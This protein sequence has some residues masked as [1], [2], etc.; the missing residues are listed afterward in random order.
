E[1]LQ[2]IGRESHAGENERRQQRPTLGGKFLDTHGA[3][4]RDDLRTGR[5]EQDVQQQEREKICQARLLVGRLKKQV[6]KRI[7]GARQRVLIGKGRF[8]EPL[9]SESAHD[10]EAKQEEDG[11]VMIKHDRCSGSSTLVTKGRQRRVACSPA[12]CAFPFLLSVHRAP[13]GASAGSASSR[14]YRIVPFRTACSP[15]LRRRTSGNN[16]SRAG[17][18]RRRGGFRG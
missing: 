8:V 7:D 17:K 4:R 1:P 13:P 12:A 11:P 14:S 2:R 16:G 9:P 10:Q 18:R 15:G 6:A 5:H 3:E